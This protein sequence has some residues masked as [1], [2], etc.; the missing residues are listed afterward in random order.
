MEVGLVH[1]LGAIL[2]PNNYVADPCTVGY[3]SSTH[4]IAGIQT[5]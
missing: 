2:N 4:R 1:D 5:H 3:S